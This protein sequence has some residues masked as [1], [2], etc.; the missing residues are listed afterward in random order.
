MVVGVDGCRDGWVAVVLQG[1]KME[2]RY[3][4]S[5]GQVEEVPGVEAVAID[6]PLGLSASGERRA[7]TLARRRLPHRAS[8]VFNVPPRI[9]LEAGEGDY[10]RANAQ[11]RREAGKGLSR[12]SFALLAKIREVDSF[13][14]SAPCPVYEVHPEL[15]FARLNAGTPLP[16]KKSREG[17]AA[18]REV[19]AAR[20]FD[21][22]GVPRPVSWRMAVDD[23]LDAAVCAWT[24][25]LIV[26][27]DV[28]CLPDPPE[29]DTTGR[30]MCIRV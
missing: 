7:E 15:S 6:I 18:R 4:E 22:A 11:S 27:G 5:I 13:W 12:Q 16:P 14:T 3:W 26:Q 24:A 25:Q 8:T 30:E 29:F 2:V 28:E 17:I 19:L 21:L 23:L 9:C 1:A 10:A 20:G